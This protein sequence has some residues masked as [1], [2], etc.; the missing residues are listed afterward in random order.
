VGS[1][2]YD[3]AIAGVNSFYIGAITGSSYEQ[4]IPDS[5]GSSLA[6]VLSLDNTYNCYWNNVSTIT[7]TSLSN[8]TS[9]TIF[10]VAVIDSISFNFSSASTS[11]IAFNYYDISMANLYKSKLVRIINCSYYDE[12]TASIIV[13]LINY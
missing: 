9:F 3:T 6:F 8:V 12:S 13:P 2:Y 11:L 4:S 1:Y 5:V 7:I 10:P